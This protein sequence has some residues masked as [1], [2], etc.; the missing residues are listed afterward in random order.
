VGNARART[1]AGRAALVVALAVA[2]YSYEPLNHATASVHVLRSPLDA[3]LPFVPLMAIPYLLFLPFVLGTLLL[4]ALADWSRFRTLALAVILAAL[5]ADLAFIAFQTYVARPPVVGD[6][7]GARLV[8]AVYAGDQP[9]NGFPSLHV[10]FSTLCLIAYARWR[11][12]Y[13]LAALPLVA[14]IIAATVL[15]RQHYLADVA[16]GLALASLAYWMVVWIT[17]RQKIFTPLAVR[18]RA[19]GER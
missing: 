8:R 7:L 10:A 1:I 9:Y 14:A 4:F 19:A 11:R 2:L 6:D 15:I 12:A 18:A 16:G 17:E 5:A 3:V 13:A